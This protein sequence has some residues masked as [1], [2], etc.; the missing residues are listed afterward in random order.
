LIGT[1][2]KVNT[3][4]HIGG[5]MEATIVKA[6]ARSANL[7]RFLNREDCPPLVC[8]LKDLFNKAFPSSSKQ[9]SSE[10]R[11]EATP[12]ALSYEC[13]HY[14]YNGVNYSRSQTHIGNSLVLF[15]ASL[16][17][18]K[19]IAG[20]IQKIEINKGQPFFHIC[21][22]QPLPS[23]KHDPFCHYPWFFAQSY[24]SEMST[25]PPDR[26]PASRIVSHVARFNF[27]NGRS[28]ILNLSR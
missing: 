10:G 2:Q 17:D 13:A 26:V 15:Y 23:S 22:Q 18:T 11:L 1:L 16:T 9:L 28:V 6:H 7:R 25:L 19:P 20:S 14:T 21:R 24:S 3:N 8:I 27:S 5:E 4:S 12:A